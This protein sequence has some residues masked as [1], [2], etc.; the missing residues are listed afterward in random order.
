MNSA[1][2]MQLD[3]CSSTSF[4]LATGAVE[5]LVVL[6]EVDHAVPVAVR[7]LEHDVGESGNFMGSDFA[8]VGPQLVFG[9]LNGY[10]AILKFP[11]LNHFNYFLQL[12]YKLQQSCYQ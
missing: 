3:L 1:S 2:F 8:V 12:N 7:D 9:D 10:S 6:V 5:P 4:V 11:I